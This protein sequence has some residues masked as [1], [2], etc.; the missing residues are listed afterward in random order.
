MKLLMVVTLAAALALS[1]AAPSRATP[2]LDEQ[3]AVVNELSLNYHKRPRPDVLPTYI[4]MVH[5]LG[6][7]NGRASGTPGVIGFLA[8]AA[9]QDPVAARTWLATSHDPADGCA[10]AQAVKLGG[11]PAAAGLLAVIEPAPSGCVDRPD[12]TLGAAAPATAAALDFIWGH[13]GATG[14]PADVRRIVSVLHQADGPVSKVD[15]EATMRTLVG[16]AAAWALSSNARRDPQLLALCR[17]LIAQAGPDAPKLQ[18][19]VAAAEAGRALYY[20]G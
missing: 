18:E 19:A 8:G 17:T 14:D 10:L 3:K 11:G 1:A 2:T 20:P 9:S 15:M 12:L 16:R 7:L 5:N 13:W 6:L 4:A